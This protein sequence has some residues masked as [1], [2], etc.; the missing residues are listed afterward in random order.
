MA[1]VSESSGQS[2]AGIDLLWI[3]PILAL[4]SVVSIEQS[5]FRFILPVIKVFVR[6]SGTSA[7]Q[8]SI[9]VE[10]VNVGPYV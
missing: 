6:Q 5:T 2:E 10:A 1:A 7:R 8:H 4:K 9:V 3:A